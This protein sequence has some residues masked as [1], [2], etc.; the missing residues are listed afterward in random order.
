MSAVT[1][2]TATDSGA[3][4]DLNGLGHTNAANAR[5]A[6]EDKLWQ[7]LHRHPGATAVHL[8][9]AAGIGKSTAGKIL[10]RWAVDGVVVRTSPPAADGS[11]KADLW[12][13]AGPDVEAGD[14]GNS[15]TTSERTS[16]P[17]VAVDTAETEKSPTRLPA[18]G[19]RGLVEDFLREHPDG[20][21]GPHDIG[22]ALGRSAGAVNNA[23]E[24]L[25]K[26]GTADKVND[27]PKRFTLAPDS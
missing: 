19:L 5:T 7:A 8:A 18:G 27:K 3:G 9:T 25:T 26:A 6:A 2:E 15:A 11:R 1:Y 23:L 13:I 17:E 16:V 24:A 4:A 21:F 14:E 12:S 10:A 20:C 22:K